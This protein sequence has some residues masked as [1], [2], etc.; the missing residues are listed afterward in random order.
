MNTKRTSDA[1]WNIVRERLSAASKA[2][3]PKAYFPHPID[4]GA[5]RTTSWPVGQIAD[6]E[7]PAPAGEAPM[8]IRE[9][10][11]RFEAFLEGVRITAAAADAADR[12]PTAAMYIGGA[13]LGGAIGASVSNRREGSLLGAGLGLLFAAVLETNMANKRRRRR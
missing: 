1:A 10:E 3:V 9:Y 11:D 2:T 12:D 7:F 13:L 4:A 6:Y 8:V 5:R